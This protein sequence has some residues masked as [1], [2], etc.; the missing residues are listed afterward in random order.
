M[1]IYISDSDVRTLLPMDHCI[2]LIEKVFIDESLGKAINLPRQNLALPR[3]AHRTITGVAQES[4]VYGMKTYTVG[5]EGT[6]IDTRYLMLVYRL[7]GMTLAAVIDAK[8][9]GQIRTGAVSGVA[10]KYLAKEDAKTLGIIGTGFEAE[11]QVEAMMLVRPIIKVKAYSRSPDNRQR[12]ASLMRER[13]GIDVDPVDSAEAC[14]RDVDIIIT[15]TS[16]SVP[17]FEASW[18]GPGTHINGVGA[19]GQYRRELD[20]QAVCCSELV[21]VENL[22]QAKADCGDLIYASE[23]GDF[24]WDRVRELHEVVSGAVPSRS[25]ENAITLFDSLGVAT[26]DLAP[27]AFVVRQALAQG[28]GQELPF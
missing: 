6:R 9:L 22:E 14:V 12:F 3:G 17:V 15:A 18:I 1:A 4:G 16:A 25:S 28:I 10:T 5:L 2:D 21:V 11:A 26:E 20:Q 13:F 19:Q 27:A 24:D 23:K 7:E 8:G